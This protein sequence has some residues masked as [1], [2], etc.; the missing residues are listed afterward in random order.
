MPQMTGEFPKPIPRPAWLTARARNAVRRPLFIGAATT[1]T[2]IAAAVALLV[3]PHQIR[4]VA[5]APIVPAAARPDTAPLIAAFTEA[6]T[7]L[8]AA[9][10]SL[11]VARSTA[12]RAPAPTVD[13]L[14]P[15]VNARRDSL[16]N[17]VNDL[18]ALLTRVETAP[19]TASYRA[20][21]ESPQL[22][23]NG[24]AKA[25]LD[26]LTAV[27]RDRDAFGTTGVADPVYVALSARVNDIGHSIQLVGQQ[28]RDSLRAQIARLSAPAPTQAVVANPAADTA[29]WIAERDS[30]QSLES[31][32][33]AALADA[34]RK[35]REYDREVEQAKEEARLDTPPMAM[36]GAALVFGVALGFAWV[37]GDETRRP[38]VSDEHEV[39]LLTGVRVLA[40]VQPRPR[41][42]DRDRRSADREA[43]P[44][45]DPGADGYQLSY[46][47][48][49]RTGASRLV[50]TIT[51]DDTRLA[52]VVA[53]NIA[54]IAADEARSTILIDTD[55][56]T[57]P[58]AAALRIH[59][60]PGF[61]DVLARAAEWPE[62]AVE[63]R[64][65]RDRTIDVVPSG[66]SPSLR[67]S[68]T[69]ELLRSDGARLARH[70]DAIVVVA[71][72]AQTAAG[73]PGALPIADTIV[74]ARVGHTRVHELQTAID[75]IRLAG[76]NPAGI[77]LWNAPAPVLPSSERIARAPRP[78]RT[79]EMRALTTP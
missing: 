17:A 18:D 64:I 37:F 67:L 29:S 20:L 1:G 57:A 5:P 15:V 26:S 63:A 49:A 21:G 59:A 60:E 41:S 44:Y 51:G 6:R 25:L 70:Y 68:E 31:Q 27:E 75:A 19:V 8:A 73:V 52:A 32:A 56:H 10:S 50:L 16:I 22:A 45:F 74:C 78:V 55:S 4:R 42:P 61:A 62:V 40:T 39:E 69:T 38:R 46:L 13:T 3:A 33:A 9:E 71:T 12:Q 43:P 54:A 2:V 11:A 65:G 28:Q 79:A 47:H 14:A 48:V 24:R 36:L 35:A 66:I 7:R 77:V 23:A 53:M 30:A 58:V 72:T 34:R 76:G